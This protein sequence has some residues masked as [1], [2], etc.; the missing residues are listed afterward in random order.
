MSRS[1]TSASRLVF[2]SKLIDHHQMILTTPVPQTRENSTLT[3]LFL[4][5]PSKL[6]PR[7]EPAA[8]PSVY[9]RTSRSSSTSSRTAMAEFVTLLA[10]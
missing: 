5:S 9:E 3:I 7:S 1:L 10:R 4:F 6:S 8:R 2:S